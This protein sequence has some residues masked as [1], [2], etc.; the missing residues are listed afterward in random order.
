MAIG[1]INYNHILQV[2]GDLHGP[3]RPNPYDDGSLG[4]DNQT[5]GY[6]FDIS[7][8]KHTK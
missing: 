1:E 7:K 3:A 6:H 2:A 4:V 8:Y 5:F